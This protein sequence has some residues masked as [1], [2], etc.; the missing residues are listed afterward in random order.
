[1]PGSTRFPYT[2]LFRSA[3]IWLEAPSGRVKLLDFG[4][5]RPAGA[6]SYLTQ[7]GSIVGTPAFMS[8]E[9]ARGEELGFRSDL[10]SL[11]AV[12]AQF[13]SEEHTSELQSL[14]YL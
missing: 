9:Q 8:P 10:F 11:G 6:I 4:L 3:N 14:A 2:T 7:A 13:R 5:A 1:P 12:E